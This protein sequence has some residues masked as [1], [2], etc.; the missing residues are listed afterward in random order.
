MVNVSVVWPLSARLCGYPR[1]FQY[2]LGYLGVLWIHRNLTQTTGSSCRCKHRGDLGSSCHLKDFFFFSEPT[3]IFTHTHT[4]F[5]VLHFFFFF[6]KYIIYTLCPK[7]R[8]RKK[9]KTVSVKVYD[10]IISLKITDLEQSLEK[11]THTQCWVTWVFYESTEI[12][13]RPQDL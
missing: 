13:H 4:H 6:F 2:M 10:C 9:S 7:K 11:H 12:W 1:R 3:Q 5:C 8:K